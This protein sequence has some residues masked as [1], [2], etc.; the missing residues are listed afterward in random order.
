MASGQ[1]IFVSRNQAMIVVQH[2]DGFAVIE[3]LGG[4][5]ALEV[6]VAVRGDWNV[7]GSGTIRANGESYEVLFQGSWGSRDIAISIARKSGGG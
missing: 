2:D 6:G 5:G 4:E 1:A 3:L 7:S